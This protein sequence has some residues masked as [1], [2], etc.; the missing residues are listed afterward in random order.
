MKFFKKKIILLS[1]SYNRLSINNLLSAKQQR[2]M[3]KS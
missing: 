1:L 3:F 2:I